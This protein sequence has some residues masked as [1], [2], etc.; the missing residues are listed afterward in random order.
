[1]HKLLCGSCKLIPHIASLENCRC[2]KSVKLVRRNDDV[3]KRLLLKSAIKHN[4]CDQCVAVVTDLM[5]TTITVGGYICF[6]PSLYTAALPDYVLTRARA[7]PNCG[8]L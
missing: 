2:L 1:M 3:M 8:Y 4:L 7:G 6:L 5:Y